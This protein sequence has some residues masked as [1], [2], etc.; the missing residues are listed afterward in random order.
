M[1]AVL[2]RVQLGVGG[3][4]GGQRGGHVQ[5]R[6]EEGLDSACTHSQMAPCTH[7]LYWI[8]QPQPQALAGVRSLGF[9][10]A[11]PAPAGLQQESEGVMR[12]MRRGHSQMH[13][14][15]LPFR[16]HSGAAHFSRAVGGLL[17]LDRAGHAAGRKLSHLLG[18]AEGAGLHG[19]ERGH[20]AAKDA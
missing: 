7:N 10:H 11:P 16:R 2:V 15:S 18:H 12:R 13:C 19:V 5:K 9:M 6:S 14:N 1:L 3:A 4:A 8:A 17:E 20:G